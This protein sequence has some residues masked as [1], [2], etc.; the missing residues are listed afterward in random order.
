MKSPTLDWLLANASKT[1]TPEAWAKSLEVEIIDDD[2]WRVAPKGYCHR[3][4]CEPIG[5]TEF[6]ERLKRCTVHF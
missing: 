6:I 5:L 1:Q 4:F 3:N 2:G